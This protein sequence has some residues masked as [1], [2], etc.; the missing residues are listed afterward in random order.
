MAGP[1]ECLCF[2]CIC[3]HKTRVH[4]CHI[5]R[6]IFQ[7]G[8][9][10]IRKLNLQPGE[11]EQ[12]LIIRQFKIMNQRD[13]RILTSMDDSLVRLSHLGQ[14]EL[15]K[16]LHDPSFSKCPNHIMRAFFFFLIKY[17]PFQKYSTDFFETTPVLGFV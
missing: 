15:Q 10:R 1:F 5:F 11:L 12:K 3:M 9:I 16:D 4:V 13:F 7:K 8:T 2:S 6:L 17:T 14:E